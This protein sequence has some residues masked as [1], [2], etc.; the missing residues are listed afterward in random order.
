MLGQNQRA[1]NDFIRLDHLIETRKLG[2]TSYIHN[3]HDNFKDWV[4]VQ[5]HYNKGKIYYADFAKSQ[6]LTSFCNS[7]ETLKRIEKESKVSLIPR[8]TTIETKIYKGKTFFEKGSYSRSLKWYLRAVQEIVEYLEIWWEKKK[9]PKDFI[10]C[11]F[12]HAL[13]DELIKLLETFKHHDI[14]DKKRLKE[15]LLNSSVITIEDIFSWE[16][17]LQKI[18]GKKDGSAIKLLMSKLKKNLLAKL[19]KTDN[20]NS[21]SYEIKR[22]VVDGFNDLKN[23]L[24]FFKDEMASGVIKG[25]P[26]LQ[27]Q[28][29]KY[30]EIIKESGDLSNLTYYQTEEIK[31]FNIVILK[32]LFPEILPESIEKNS[33]G[34]YKLHDEIGK[35][36]KNREDKDYAE[37]PACKLDRFKDKSTQMSLSNLLFPKIM[38]EDGIQKSDFK[39]KGTWSKLRVPLENLRIIR[40]I[41]PENGKNTKDYGFS[42]KINNKIVDEIV[43]GDVLRNS[44]EFRDKEKEIAEILSIWEKKEA[45]KPMAK[46]LSNVL[47]RI[48]FILFDLRLSNEPD[49]NNHDIAL[50]WIEKALCLNGKNGY[51]TYNMISINEARKE[52]SQDKKYTN[53]AKAFENIEHFHSRFN[54]IILHW[55]KQWQ[56]D[57]AKELKPNQELK[58]QERYYSGL[59]RAQLKYFDDLIRKPAE[60]YEYLTRGR[61]VPKYTDD[62]DDKDHY[63]DGLYFLGRYSSWTPKI[64]RPRVFGIKGG[65]KFLVWKSKGIVID[66]GFDFLNNFYA[67]G[68]S[69][70]DI[71]AVIVTHDHHD[72]TDDFESMWRLIKEHNDVIKHSSLDDEGKEKKSHKADA[73]RKS[74]IFT[75]MF[76]LSIFRIRQNV[77]RSYLP[78]K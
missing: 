39:K 43:L 18:K 67:E 24:E 75:K 48:G 28:L 65:G 45:F 57:R 7:M 52:P 73:V 4:K 1:F 66:P 35:Q 19:N 40:K 74:G 14:I 49:G 13:L 77:Y 15:K 36:H 60:I 58:P 17:L 71:D 2:D 38:V 30:K 11:P 34:F 62:K 76:P 5:I 46:M 69:L 54:P 68:F 59:L 33:Q 37:C 20:A 53:Y 10:W 44:K 50:G 70:E 55:L 47:N 22:V 56:N 31:W 32:R 29:I 23:N 8:I 16:D 25:S 41:T 42:K 78:T 64:P 21:L 27:K 61:T 9:R 51:A 26:E 6:A 72:H 12:Q 3:E 63:M